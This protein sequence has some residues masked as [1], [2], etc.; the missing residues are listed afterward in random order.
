MACRS[1]ELTSKPGRS[2]YRLNRTA[3]HNRFQNRSR[4]DGCR[5]FYRQFNDYDYQL[6]I[7]YPDTLPDSLQQTREQFEDEARWALAVKLF[8]M[9]RISSGLAAQLVETDRITF[10]S[11][12]HRYNVPMIDLTEEE[13]QADLDNA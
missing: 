9:K 6:K 1:T 5:P 8:E 12:L 2:P 11:N 4:T 10:L 3:S 13:L 7:N